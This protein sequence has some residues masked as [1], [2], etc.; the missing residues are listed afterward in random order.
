LARLSKKIKSVV[1]L[2]DSLEQLSEINK[3]VD[4]LIEMN[5]PYGEKSKNYEKLTS[6]LSQA[7]QIH[8]KISKSL[9]K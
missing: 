9:G 4:E 3:S 8:S 6:Y 7:N 2:T 5:V 1:T